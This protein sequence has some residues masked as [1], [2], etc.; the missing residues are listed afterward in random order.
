M[1]AESVLA[2]RREHGP[3]FLQELE[4]WLRVE[5]GQGDCMVAA[6]KNCLEEAHLLSLPLP[7]GVHWPAAPLSRN[8]RFLFR[9]Q[10]AH[11]LGW[12]DK[13]VEGD[14]SSFS[15]AVNLGLRQVWWPDEE[16][17]EL[18]GTFGQPGLR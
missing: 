3:Q 12:K 14:P 9:R 6:V 18:H 7:K 15:F 13:R 8:F 5:Q 16:A 10:V 2:V 11:L 17:T 1:V 4:R